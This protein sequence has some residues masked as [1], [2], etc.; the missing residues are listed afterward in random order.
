MQ[1]KD[2][3]YFNPADEEWPC[4][5]NIIENKQASRHYLASTIVSVFHKT[6]A[7]SWG[8]RLE[9]L[10]RNTILALLECDNSTLLGAQQLLINESYRRKVIEKITDP[11]VKSYWQDE[12][13]HYPDRFLREV[14]SPLQNILLVQIVS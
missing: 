1:I 2:T 13:A 6:W 8:P 14:I 3:I 4:G 5:Y 9:H 7:D 11:I 10:L 12:F